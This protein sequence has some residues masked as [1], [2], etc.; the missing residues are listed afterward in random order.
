MFHDYRVGV[1][2]HAEITMGRYKDLLGEMVEDLPG[3]RVVLMVE[4]PGKEER[5]RIDISRSRIAYAPT[6]EQI[7]A[8]TEELR[9]KWPGY[10][11]QSNWLWCGPSVEEPYSVPVVHD[12]WGAEA[13]DSV[14]AV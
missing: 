8:A 10:R 3:S 7:R 4:I 1:G 14:R 6:R 13:F 9:S 12:Y 5:E 2:D 11:F